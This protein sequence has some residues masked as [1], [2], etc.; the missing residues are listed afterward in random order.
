MTFFHEYV[1]SNSQ[2][3]L[4]LICDNYTH[5]KKYIV[6]QQSLF[7]P[8]NSIHQLPDQQENVNYTNHFALKINNIFYPIMLFFTEL[9]VSPCYG[10]VLNKSHGLNSIK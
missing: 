5:R 3:V 9:H 6:K 4:Y 10:K 2:Y 8:Q 7:N 1:L